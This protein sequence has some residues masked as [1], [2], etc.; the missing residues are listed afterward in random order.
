MIFEQE[1]IDAHADEGRADAEHVEQRQRPARPP[2]RA[3]RERSSTTSSLAPAVSA[4][5]LPDPMR[6]IA[7]AGSRSARASARLGDQG[8]AHDDGAIAAAE[9]DEVG[10][11]PDIGTNGRASLVERAREPYASG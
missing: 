1:C 7:I 9:D 2:P 4:I 3:S 10:A 11:S 6:R 8:Q 5:A